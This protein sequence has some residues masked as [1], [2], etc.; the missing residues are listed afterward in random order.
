MRRAALE[1]L[2]RRDDELRRIGAR[3]AGALRDARRA[4]FRARRDAA[5]AELLERVLAD[6]GIVEAL[7]RREA[8]LALER[9]GTAAVVRP[10]DDADPAARKVMV[11][12]R[13][14]VVAIEKL[15]RK[16]EA[17]IAKL[18]GRT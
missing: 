16:V 8:Y 4:L 13:N 11:P 1:A 12:T 7:V 18:E 2:D 10:K 17:E 6:R 14:H 9:G 5:E 15:V 3:Y